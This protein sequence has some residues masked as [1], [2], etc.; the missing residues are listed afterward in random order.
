MFN[1]RTKEE[2]F[3][4]LKNRG[5]TSF[6]K[7]SCSKTREEGWTMREGRL[8]GNLRR[9]EKGV[10]SVRPPYKFVS[11]RGVYQ[12]KG[13]E[14]KCEVERE[15]SPSRTD[16]Y[17]FCTNGGTIWRVA[18]FKTGEGRYV[19]VKAWVSEEDAIG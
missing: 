2:K 14:D 9:T 13:G 10:S 16:S 8:S 18:L 3:R 4:C 11:A 12:P 1:C 6:A 17:N 7:R 19:L 5:R 15:R